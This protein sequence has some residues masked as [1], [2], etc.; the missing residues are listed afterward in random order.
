MHPI[1][2]NGSIK[3]T[4]YMSYDINLKELTS[5]VRPVVMERGLTFAESSTLLE[6]VN[7]VTSPATVVVWSVHQVLWGIWD[8]STVTL[9]ESKEINM[10]FATEIRVFSEKEELHVYKNKKGSWVGRHIKDF[11]D[12]MSVVMDTVDS[13]ARLIGDEIRIIDEKFLEC[14]DSG[15]KISQII[16]KPNTAGDTYGLITRNYVDYVEETGQAT[17]SDYRFVAI[18]GMKKG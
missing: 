3:G 16:P 15:R 10:D 9:P 17:Y 4:V 8:G 5:T 14:K 6:F 2:T 1:F 18:V 7:K 12:D 11:E 13:T